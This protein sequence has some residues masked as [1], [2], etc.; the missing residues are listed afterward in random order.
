MRV[1]SV[2]AFW[3]T[4]TARSVKF[5]VAVKRLLRGRSEPDVPFVMLEFNSPSY[6]VTH[7]EI[8][9]VARRA[10]LVITSMILS[11]IGVMALI[12]V[13][14]V[15]TARGMVVSKIS[16]TVVQSLEPAIIRSILVREGQ[17][18]SP[19][20][21]LARLDP[22]F[23]SADRSNLEGQVERLSAYMARLQAE[24][25]KTKFSGAEFGAEGALQASIFGFRQGEFESRLQTF[26]QLISQL[27]SERDRADQDLITNQERLTVAEEIETMRKDLEKS[28]A[29][30]KLATLQAVDARAE[31]SGAMSAARFKSESTRQSLAA[32]RAEKTSFIQHWYADIGQSLADVDN[33][34]N[35]LRAELKKANLREDLVEIRAR[36]AGVVQSIAPLSVG[37]VLAAGQPLMT[38]VPSSAGLEIEAHISARDS[39]FVQIGNDVS[40]KFDAFSFSSYGMYWG[41]LRV[42]SPDAFLPQQNTL[43]PADAASQDGGG[44][45][46]YRSVISLDRSELRNLPKDFVLVPGMPV[47]AD[48]KVGE[49]SVLSY[50][51]EK[52][53]PV[54]KEGFR[55]P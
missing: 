3:P 21:L 15:V 11:M 31:L 12:S 29:G 20:D 24:A 33:Q 55:E 25:N 14:R 36:T 41:T 5:G 39:G 4:F 32:Q 46:Y 44:D 28:N 35:S 8:P 37:S 19:G 49:R 18:V 16:D 6:A 30:S 10:T 9:A 22:T 50:F 23:V 52:I 43:N 13:D 7:A 48:I 1:P 17:H 54:A 40:I 26:D 27:E 38:V 47:R 34:L 53:V 51:L 42:I 45:P 2:E